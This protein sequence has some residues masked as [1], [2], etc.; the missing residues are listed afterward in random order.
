MSDERSFNWLVRNPSALPASLCRTGTALGLAMLVAV[1]AV[2]LV[3][4]WAGALENPLGPVPLL[5]AGAATATAAAA[6]RAGWLLVPSKRAAPR[7]DRAVMLLTLLAVLTLGAG[8]CVA[9]TSSVGKRC[10][11]TL[12]AVE[13]GLAWAWYLG[14]RTVRQPVPF[15][16]R[17][18]C[19]AVVQD[20]PRTGWQPVPRNPRTGWQP[21]PRDDL[22]PKD[23]VQQLTRSRAADGAESIAGWLRLPFAAGQRT[24]SVHV[25]FCPPLA[26]AP[27]LSVEQIGGP[28]ARV[29]TAQLLPYGVR[30]DLKLAAAAEEPADVLLQFS[31]RTV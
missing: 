8:L 10:L 30:L 11:F 19:E 24:G 3:R 13:E 12:L 1:A 9:G 14:R 28:E 4:R 20:N 23:V 25:A 21:V 2:V 17:M 26:A 15:G 18:A 31:A 6:I 29:K 16:R 22:P 7:R 27:A 5:T